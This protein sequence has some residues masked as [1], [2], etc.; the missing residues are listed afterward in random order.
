MYLL[1]IYIVRT[2]AKVES[3]VEVNIDIFLVKLILIYSYTYVNSL[4]T[5][6]QN[7]NDNKKK[8]IV[9]L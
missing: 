9:K 5:P 7:N 8:S 3:G 4:K 1:G 2:L 6:I